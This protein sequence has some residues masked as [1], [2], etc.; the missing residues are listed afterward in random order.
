MAVT[1]VSELRRKREKRRTRNMLIK[2]FVVILLCGI[3]VVAVFTRNTWMP[4]FRGILSRIPAAVEQS[5]SSTTEL[6]GGNFP[7]SIEGGADYQICAVGDSLALLDDSRFHVYS[8]NGKVMSEKQHTYA[9]PILAANSSKALIYDL[10][11]RDFSLEGKY[12]N[13]YEKTADDVI[14][15]A[16]LSEKDYVAV[17]TKSENLLSMLKVYDGKGNEIFRYSSYDGRIID[18]AFNTDSSGCV[19][20]VISAE[21]GDLMSKMIRFDFSDTAVQWESEP[22]GTIA[23]NVRFT[24]DGS[25]MMVGDTLTALYSAD[26]VLTG[27]YVY[28]DTIVDYSST[29]KVTAIITS[30]T[31]KRVTRLILITPDTLGNP[32]TADLDYNTDKV[33]C[34][35]EQ[36]H[37]L[38]SEGVFTYDITGQITASALLED[39]YDGLCRISGYMYLLG[40]DSVS[41][42]EY[43]S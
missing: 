25:I 1:D 28:T 6:S 37:I 34:E 14:L 9:N 16:K 31:A 17:V 24:D 29:D 40:Y 21:N 39:D 4:A 11:G 15:L 20:T 32:I 38:N 42:I 2:G 3:A 18:V 36:S 19:L 30:N 43:V 5:T 41:C 13:V 33:Y 26:G 7:I 8:A 35:G 22:I 27:T 12:K 10:G 23:L